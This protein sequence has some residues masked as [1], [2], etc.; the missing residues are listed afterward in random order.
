VFAA[1]ASWVWFGERLSAL[2]WSGGGLILA[3]MLLAEVPRGD[4]IS[5]PV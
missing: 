1:L 2:Q 5:E 3:G 4:V